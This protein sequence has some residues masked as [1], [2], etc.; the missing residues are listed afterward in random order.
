MNT[1]KLVEVDL[2]RAKEHRCPGIEVG[3]DYLC[4]INGRLF[5][6]R[7]SEQ[8]FGLNFDGWLNVGLQFDAPGWNRS[9]WERV[10][11]IDL[12]RIGVREAE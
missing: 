11:R 10:W 12:P 4:Q 9:M 6:G 7:F 2:T 5:A 3:P 8:W 1:P